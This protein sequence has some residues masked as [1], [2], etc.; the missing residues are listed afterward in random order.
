MAALDGKVVLIAGGAGEVGEGLVRG[1]L[2]NGAT[3]IVPSRSADKLD[4]LHRQ[5]DQYGLERLVTLV[6]DTGTLAGVETLRDHIGRVVGQLDAVVASLGGW[7]QGQPLTEI[8]VDLWH[9]LIDQGLTAHFVFA[10]TFLP[11]IADQ[12][13]SSY[14]LINGAGALSAV[15]QAGP[16]SISAAAQLM[17]KD[18]LAAEYE[19][20]RVRINSLVLATPV[21]TR[22]R[23]K[24]RANWLTADAAGEYAA[25]LAS[26]AA[27][28]LRGETIIFRDKKQLEELP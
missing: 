3:V 2:R 28:N 6:A 8:S 25:F 1:F 15:P 12:P 22:S 10:R 11:I 19:N 27:L 5:V 9:Q 24:G 20:S 21:V 17:L 26:D 23:P 18:V 16:I 4:Q 7:W 13:G 14:T